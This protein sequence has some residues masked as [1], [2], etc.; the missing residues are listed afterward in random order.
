MPLALKIVQPKSKGRKRVLDDFEI[1]TLNVF[2][3]FGDSEVFDDLKLAI[4]DS[5]LR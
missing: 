3:E 2:V 1:L 5:S 4:P